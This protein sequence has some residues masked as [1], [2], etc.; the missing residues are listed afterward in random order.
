VCELDASDIW[1]LMAIGM[2]AWYTYDS[3]GESDDAADDDGAFDDGGESD[4]DDA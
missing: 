2:I 1:D 4:D 3:V